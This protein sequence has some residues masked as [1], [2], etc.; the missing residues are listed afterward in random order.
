MI[1]IYILRIFEHDTYKLNVLREYNAGYRIG[2][3]L[4]CDDGFSKD[5][6]R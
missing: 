1:T 3:Q 2:L 4:R 6:W 5:R